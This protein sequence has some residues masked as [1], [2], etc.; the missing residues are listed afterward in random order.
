MSHPMSEPAQEECVNWASVPRVGLFSH[1]QDD[2][3]FEQCR[4]VVGESVDWR[5]TAFS[6]GPR[7][8]PG[9]A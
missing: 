2:E 5:A 7:N 3:A 9:S 8:A 4:P 6:A 1:M